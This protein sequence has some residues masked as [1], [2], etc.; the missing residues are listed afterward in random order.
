MP[1]KKLFWDDPYMKEC[2][3]KVLKIDNDK[4]ILDQTIFYAFSGGQASDSGS[5]NEIPVKEALAGDEFVYTLE[6]T[7]NLKVGDKVKVKIDW[8][9][10][11][12]IM[13]LHSAAHVIFYIFE[14]KTGANKLIGSNVTE[15]KSRLDYEY[16]ENI[17]KFLPDVENEANEVFSQNIPVKT[18]FD[19]KNPGKRLWEPEGKKEWLCPCGGT[20]VKNLNEIGRVKLKRKNIGSGK[21]R[22][23]ITL[24]E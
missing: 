3:A 14:K 6:Q 24:S 20:H 22:I 15:E 17:A 5:I 9:K 19:D 23:E 2:E 18:Y 12:K 16:P 8:D 10:R 1:T 13:R 4:V 7:P 21:E 11:F